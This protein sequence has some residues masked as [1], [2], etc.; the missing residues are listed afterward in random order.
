MQLAI[1]NQLKVQTNSP[2]RI[3]QLFTAYIMPLLNGLLLAR[4]HHA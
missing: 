3:L 1:I 2:N 4:A